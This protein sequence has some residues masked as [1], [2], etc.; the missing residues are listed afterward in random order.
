M[1]EVCA[2]LLLA[3]RSSLLAPRSSLLAP[4]SSLLAARCSL[5]AAH[6]D[7]AGDPHAH[8][9]DHVDVTP[10][11]CKLSREPLIGT[12]ELP[13]LWEEFG[14]LGQNVFGRLLLGG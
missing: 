4:R 6:V 7:R 1:R 11:E 9:G 2:R 3:A 5:L 10:V 14:K 13:S 12:V 8:R